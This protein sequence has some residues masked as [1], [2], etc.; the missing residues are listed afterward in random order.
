MTHLAAY[1]ASARAV[2]MIEGFDGFDGFDRF[3]GFSLVFE[4][5]LT[6]LRQV[7]GFVT[8]P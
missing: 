2:R 1:F 4:S 5:F 7:Y 8:G 6:D 3:D